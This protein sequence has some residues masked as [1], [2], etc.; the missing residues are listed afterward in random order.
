MI[1]PIQQRVH[2]T[3]RAAVQ[4]QFGLTEVPPFAIETPPNRA[5]GDLAVTVAFQ[6]ARTLRKAPRAI[7]QD[8]ATAIGTIPGV[9]RIVPTPNGYL[10]LYLERPAFVV[11]RMTNAAPQPSGRV[12]KNDR[13]A[14]GHQSQQ[15]RARRPPAQRHAR[16]HAGAGAPVLRH[17]CGSAE[18]HRRHGR[19]GRRR[20]RRASRNSSRSR[21]TMSGTSQRRRGSTTTA[22]TCTRGSPNGTRP[23][24]AGSTFER[25][26]CTS[27]STAATTRRTWAHSSSIGSCT[28]I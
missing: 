25:G 12:G 10:N 20:H 18:L 9:E 4:Q 27:S 15:S 8:L 13:R 24:R 17:A 22:G 7:A 5:L 3:V 26:R 14:H 28:R 2:D 16:R 19:S 1:L 21:S 23:T 6:L 11:A